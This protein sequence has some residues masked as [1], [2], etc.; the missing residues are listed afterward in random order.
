MTHMVARLE[1]TQNGFTIPL[2][3][4]MVE[5]LQLAE[6]SVVEVLPVTVPAEEP[7]PQIQYASVE[8]VM[9][10]YRDTL[11]QHEAAYRELAK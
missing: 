9:Q 10:A 11:P 1:K 2:T 5:A 4:E 6:G 8:E 3:T 7:R